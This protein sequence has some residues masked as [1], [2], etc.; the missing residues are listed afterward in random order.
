MFT[1]NTQ[2][3]CNYTGSTTLKHKALQA[4]LGF[5]NKNQISFDGNSEPSH[6]IPLTFPNQARLH[7]AQRTGH[8]YHHFPSLSFPLRVKNLA[9]T[10]SPPPPGSPPCPLQPTVIMALLMMLLTT[11]YDLTW[12]SIYCL[13]VTHM[14]LSTP[15]PTEGPC[16]LI[17]PSAHTC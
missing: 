6:Q 1:V 3:F 14:G 10:T 16:L 2:N 11:S 4:A 15:L 8:V 13:R 17:L 7:R 12:A 5:R 9:Q